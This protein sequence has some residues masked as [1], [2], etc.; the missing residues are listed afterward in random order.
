MRKY[1][2]SLVAIA[3]IGTS[4]CL[5]KAFTKSVINPKPRMEQRAAIPSTTT[6][7]TTTKTIKPNGT[8]V[9]TTTTTT[10]KTVTTTP[11]PPMP[12]SAQHKTSCHK[13]HRG[14][15]KDC[16]KAMKPIH[17]K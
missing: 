6:I 11:P 14:T 7:T 2:F 12:K 10:T 5:A 1:I 16:K 8:K 13:H 9:I 4:T 15:C 3:V 17:K